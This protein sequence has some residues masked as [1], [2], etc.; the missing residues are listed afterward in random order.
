MQPDEKL[1]MMANQIAKNLRVQGDERA[2]PA[3]ADHIARFWDPRMRARIIAHL[4]AGAADL[5]PL[6]R[7]AVE[8]LAAGRAA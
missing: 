2:I 3:I 8:R 1:V 5:D 7:A 6:A 4:A